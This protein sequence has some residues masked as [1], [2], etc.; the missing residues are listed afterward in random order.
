MKKIIILVFAVLSVFV[1]TACG[2]NS[3]KKEEKYAD[4]A[5]I[6]SLATGLE[7][8]WDLGSEFDK[9]KNPSDNESKD[10]ARKA[11]KIELDNVSQYKNRSFENTKLQ[12]LAL[13]Y[14]NA[15]K[16]SDKLIDGIDSFDGMKAFKEN[17][18]VRSKLL[19]TFKKD[20]GLKV[21]EKYKE[22]FD[23]IESNGQETLKND[24]VKAKVDTLSKNIK[25][26]EIPTEYSGTWKKYQATVENTTGV[27]LEYYSGEVNLLDATGVTVHNTY[28]SAKN[29]KAG[30][31][32]RFEFTTDKKFVKTEITPKYNIAE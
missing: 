8:R 9:V 16:D 24:E 30:T 23:K 18:N 20:Y 31:K 32:V 10:F 28:I 22:D 15:V 4:K 17:Y 29:W 27:N 25:F 19:V 7:K 13:Q 21:G 12:A 1:L 5:F 26:E 3:S 2:N 14:I 11:M 6:N